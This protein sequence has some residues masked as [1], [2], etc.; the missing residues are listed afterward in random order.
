MTRLAALVQQFEEAA[1]VNVD[2]LARLKFDPAEQQ[3]APYARAS[4]YEGARCYA[5]CA[6]K[7]KALF[8]DLALQGEAAVKERELL[9]LSN[10]VCACGCPS[11][12]HENYGED[13]QSC[14][15]ASHECVPTSPAVLQMLTVLRLQ[16]EAGSPKEELHESRSPDGDGQGMVSPTDSRDQMQPHLRNGGRTERGESAGVGSSLHGSAFVHQIAGSEPADSHY[17]QRAEHAEAQVAT[18]ESRCEAWEDSLHVVRTANAGLRAEVANLQQ[19]LAAQKARYFRLL[20]QSQADESRAVSAET[21]L[22]SR[23]AQLSE[24]EAENGV[25]HNTCGHYEE[26]IQRLQAQIAQQEPKCR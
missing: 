26:Q 17:Q 11:E 10:A 2:A 6:S 24:Y 8:P 14:G 7:I 9:R 22:A 25:L 12:A 4:A 23:Q 3:S 21:E 1:Q 19:E 20:E 16:G 13:G 15:E 18:L 5:E